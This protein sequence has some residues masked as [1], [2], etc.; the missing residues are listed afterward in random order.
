MGRGGTRVR[1]SGSHARFGR[2]SRIQ[3]GAVFVD[4]T[5]RPSRPTPPTKNSL[6]QTMRCYLLD[7]TEETHKI[8]EYNLISKSQKRSPSSIKKREERASELCPTL[9]GPCSIITAGRIFCFT[10]RHCGVL[11]AYI[12]AAT[13]NTPLTQLKNMWLRDNYLK[14]LPVASTA[15]FYRCLDCNLS[16]VST[17]LSVKALRACQVEPYLHDHTHAFTRPSSD[18]GE[19]KSPRTGCKTINVETILR[20]KSN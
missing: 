1:H 17:S 10:I 4:S 6:Q 11:Y 3:R 18:Y 19:S 8:I 16:P 7:P 12:V 5:P 14:H 13:S 2:H 9:L 15:V 20:R